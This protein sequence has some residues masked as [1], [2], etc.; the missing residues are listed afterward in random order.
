MKAEPNLVLCRR[1]TITALGCPV[2]IKFA[3]HLFQNT[4]PSTKGTSRKP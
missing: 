4:W 2:F 1:A 3:L